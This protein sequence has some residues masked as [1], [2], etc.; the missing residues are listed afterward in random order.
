[1]PNTS[2][3][4]L[5]EQLRSLKGK[6]SSLNKRQTTNRRAPKTAEEQLCEFEMAGLS[7]FGTQCL[8][9]YDGKGPFKTVIEDYNIYASFYSQSDR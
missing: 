9:I 1:M 7:P 8:P 6:Y 4:E 5:E 3:A 2:E